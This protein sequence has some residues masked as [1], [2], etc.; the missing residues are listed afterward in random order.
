MCIDALT[1]LDNRVEPIEVVNDVFL[2]TINSPGRVSS[3]V[4]IGRIAILD[5]TGK[6]SINDKPRVH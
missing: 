4:V 3:E 1:V 5:A 2:V 6:H